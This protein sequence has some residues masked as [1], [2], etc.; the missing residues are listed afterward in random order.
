MLQFVFNDNYKLDKRHLSKG[1]KSH[2]IDDYI[3]NKDGTV[4]SIKRNCVLK[5]HKRRDGYYTVRIN[6]KD[7]PI[8]RLVAKKYIPNPNN[9]PVVNHKNKIKTYNRVENLEWCTSKQ[10]S[11][12][13]IGK[14]VY[15]Y[16]LWGNLIKV[17]NSITEINLFEFNR[18]IIAN[19]CRLKRCII[20]GY[21]FSYVPLEYSE[22]LNRINK[23]PIYRYTKYAT[24]N[25]KVK[26][27]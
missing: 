25:T 8:H 12:H 27:K 24:D 1:Y 6:R 2:T 4:F 21:V 14:K 7:I 17:Y 19:S 3:I 16:D 23:S 11:I 15:Q 18:K 10:N 9:Y 22:I 13:G 5:P 26:S 20:N